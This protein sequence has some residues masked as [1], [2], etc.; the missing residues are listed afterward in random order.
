[1]LRNPETHTSLIHLFVPEAFERLTWNQ[2]SICNCNSKQK[3]VVQHWTEDKKQPGQAAGPSRQDQLSLTE[4]ILFTF[5]R[6][7]FYSITC[8]QLLCAE[9]Q[10]CLS[11]YIKYLYFGPDTHPL[12]QIMA[13]A[14]CWMTDITAPIRLP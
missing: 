3:C 5:I 11:L 10:L 7:L 9:P 13:Q 4:L 6:S 8:V 2:S 14:T 1:M 12:A